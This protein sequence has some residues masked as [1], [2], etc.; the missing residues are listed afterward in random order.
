MVHWA[1]YDIIPK[2]TEEMNEQERY[3]SIQIDY[4]EALC[5]QTIGS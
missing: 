1:T 5:K 3:N 4:L 2:K